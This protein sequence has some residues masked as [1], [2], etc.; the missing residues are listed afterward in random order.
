[1]NK[2]LFISIVICIICILMFSTI[3]SL[4][5]E[6]AVILKKPGDLDSNGKITKSEITT[7]A[8]RIRT[9]YYDTHKNEISRADAY[10]DG[11]IDIADIDIL[12]KYYNKQINSLP[13]LPK[14]GDVNLD[15]NVDSK[16]SALLAK[17]V[18]NNKYYKDGTKILSEAGEANADVYKD[19]NIK[20]VGIL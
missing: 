20:R 1:M 3:C 6:A 2:K 7:I 14:M 12:V 5:A 8:R 11:K 9:K 18:R 16:D 17:Y 10:Q 13:Y 15:G 4:N 19:G